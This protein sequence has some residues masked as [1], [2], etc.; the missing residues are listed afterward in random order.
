ML[1]EKMMKLLQFPIDGLCSPSCLERVAATA[2]SALPPDAP[3]RVAFVCSRVALLRVMVFL[4]LWVVLVP[5]TQKLFYNVPSDRELAVPGSHW[6]ETEFKGLEYADGVL[7]V[8]VG[9]A[10]CSAA[11]PVPRFQGLATLIPERRPCPLLSDVVWPALFPLKWLANCFQFLCAAMLVVLLAT[12]IGCAILAF[13]L[14][15]DA[16]AMVPGLLDQAYRFL[17]GMIKFLRSS[18]AAAAADAAAAAASKG[19]GSS[20]VS[21]GDFGEMKESEKEP[22]VQFFVKR[23]TTSVVRGSS[24]DVVSDILQLHSDEYAVC[25]SHLIKMDS[26]LSQNGIGNGSNVQVLR[27]LRGGAGAYLDVPGQW[28]CK[29]CHATRCWPARKR[30]YRCDAP[31]DTA[32]NST[33]MGPLG[34]AP[35]QS[36]SSGPPSRSSVP[37]HVPPRNAS[38]VSTSPPPGAGVGPSPG[39]A[40]VEKKAEASDLLQALSLLQRI[41]SP[42]DFVK[43]QVWV[44]PPKPG[45][46]REQELADR[47]KSLQRLRTQE[48]THRGAIDK[49]ELDLQRQKDMLQGVLS[50][51]RIESE[52]CDELRAQVAKEKAPAESFETVPPTQ[53]D[54]QPDEMYLSTV[55]EESGDESMLMGGSTG[56]EDEMDVGRDNGIWE[57]RRSAIIKNKRMVKL[58]DK[59]K[60][61]SKMCKTIV[62]E[63]EK[64]PAPPDSG[65]HL[66]EVISR[67]SQD[68]IAELGA[69]Y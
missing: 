66:A 11:L 40:E 29:V 10:A 57:R 2:P 26:T 24:L 59:D 5:V 23:G 9:R 30:C 58:K 34:R 68:Q 8:F 49:L 1:A 28:E 55:E 45:K 53:C 32:P 41:M 3:C 63:E 52:E 22:R 44:S 50:R 15:G 16:A 38:A 36:R 31:R 18:T 51:I 35:P 69:I 25:G 33:P 19:D 14:G 17:V 6:N 48:T 7:P 65:K 4:H 67:L 62:I 56:A 20:K 27:R 61:K 21:K 39:N 43:Y 13:K 64:P 47:V 37:R 54:S 12:L 46:T 42:E 60:L